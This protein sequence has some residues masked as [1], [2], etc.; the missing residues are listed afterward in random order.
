[1]IDGLSVWL[2]GGCFFNL[3]HCRLILEMDFRADF[4]NHIQ[5]D[6]LTT[7]WHLSAWVWIRPGGRRMEGE[8]MDKEKWSKWKLKLDEWVRWVWWWSV[9]SHRRSVCAVHMAFWQVCVSKRSRRDAWSVCPCGPSVTWGEVRS[10]VRHGAGR[11]PPH[12]YALI[13]RASCVPLAPS[14]RPSTG[15]PSLPLAPLPCRFNRG[16]TGGSGNYWK[17]QYCKE[18]EHWMQCWFKCI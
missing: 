2:A 4:I 6:R 13:R 1:M 18:W 7:W 14:I 10:C 3:D 5:L 15:S 8:C 17:L 12:R 16:G 11:E 9:C